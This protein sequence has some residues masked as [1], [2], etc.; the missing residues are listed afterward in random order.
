MQKTNKILIETARLQMRE[1]CQSDTDAVY[2]FST[3][4]EVTKYTGDGEL[5]KNKQDAENIIKSIWLAEYEKYGYARYALIHKVD[6][7]VI[8]FCG[9]KYEPDILGP[10]I[11]CPDIGYRMLPDYWGQGLGT[12]AVK[13]CLNYAREKLGLARIIGEVAEGNIASNKLLLKL[14]F[15]LTKKYVRDVFKLN[16]YE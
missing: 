3:N 15:K 10:G 1:F 11:G 4:P 5:I 6:N 13:A 7:K 9:V 16:R 2:D 14:G 8:G 12:E